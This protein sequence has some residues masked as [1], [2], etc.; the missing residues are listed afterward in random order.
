MLL[1][2]RKM[3]RRLVRYSR[4]LG[5]ER[6]NGCCCLPGKCAGVVIENDIRGE[7]VKRVC[8]CGRGV[9][10]GVAEVSITQLSTC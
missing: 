8:S 2:G 4:P 3:I 9:Y 7:D 5:E 6:E 1:S 10:G